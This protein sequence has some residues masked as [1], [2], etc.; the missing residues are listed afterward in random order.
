MQH[1]GHSLIGRGLY[2]LQ[3]E[4]YLKEFCSQ[5]KVLSIKHIQGDKNEIQNN[6]NDVFQFI[7]LPPHDLEDTSAKNSRKY[8]AMQPEV[9]Q[10]V[11][12]LRIS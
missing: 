8:S 4:P 2:A 10:C 6:M 7:G 12:Y 9:C 1:G 11:L 5:I 3:L